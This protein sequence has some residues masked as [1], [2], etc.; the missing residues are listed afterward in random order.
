M[1]VS[2][3]SFSCNLHVSM[4][5]TEYPATQLYNDTLFHSSKFSLHCYVSSYSQTSLYHKHTLLAN[6]KMYVTILI[7]TNLQEKYN[8]SQIYTAKLCLCTWR[9]VI[10]FI[11]WPLHT[12]KSAPHL[13]N[14][15]RLGRSQNLSRCSREEIDL[16]SLMGTK[17]Q[18]LGQ[19][20]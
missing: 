8:D 11:T 20:D 18:L 13:L 7:T 5:R 19:P 3:D 6:H 17:P 1:S 10:S 16:L 9:Q 12:W 4:H 14:M 15:R 2:F